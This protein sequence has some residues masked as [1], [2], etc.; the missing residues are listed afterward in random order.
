MTDLVHRSGNHSF[1]CPPATKGSTGFTLIELLVVI[2]IIALLIGILL[3]AL[4]SARKS[5]RTVACLS[6]IKQWGIGNTIFSNDYKGF[7]PEDGPDNPGGESW[8]VGNTSTPAWRTDIWWGNQ[9]VANLDG[10]PYRKLIDDAASRGMPEDVPL[11]GSDS[12]F[13][14]PDATMPEQ[15][16]DGV[17]APYAIAFASPAANFYFSYVPNSKLDASSPATWRNVVNEAGNRGIAALTLD[18]MRHPSATIQ[19]IEL[20]STRAEYDPRDGQYVESDGDV[21]SNQTNRAK[22]DWKR[23]AR[24]HANN[25]NMVFGD[26]HGAG[27]DVAYADDDTEPDAIVSQINGRNKSDLIWNPLGPARD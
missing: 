25:C 14:C 5:A 27:V 17:A 6:N 18:Q 23:M 12:I 22:G 9:V 2:S 3:P 4:G 16:I 26:G 1:G 10:D 19:M 8:R 24:R 13:I 20:R 7:L 11:P 15:S 21:I